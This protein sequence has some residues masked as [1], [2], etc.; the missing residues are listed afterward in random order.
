MKSKTEFFELVQNSYQLLNNNENCWRNK[1][2]YLQSAPSYQLKYIECMASCHMVAKIGESYIGD[3]LDI[4]M[5]KHTGWSFEDTEESR[6]SS[7]LTSYIPNMDVYHSSSGLGYKLNIA[8]QF[9]FSSSLQ[10][11]SKSHF[12]QKLESILI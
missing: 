3:P 7:F 4:E 10:S 2:D 9:D 6:G 5:F 12:I 8:K 1:E 11:M